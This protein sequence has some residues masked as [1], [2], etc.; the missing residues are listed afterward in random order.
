[1]QDAVAQGQA[2]GM[3]PPGADPTNAI[4]GMLGGLMNGGGGPGGGGGRG[5][6]GGGGGGRG[7]RGGGGGGGGGAFRNFN[8]AQPHGSIFY[9]G[10]NS[11]LNSA[12]WSPNLTPVSKPE[13]YSNNY[14]LTIG[15]S[16]YIPG[17]TK[18][19]TK[20]F[21]FI[22]LTGKKNLTA[23][24]FNGTVPTAL[25]RAGNFLGATTGGSTGSAIT[26][27]DPVT[28]AALLNNNLANASV[29]I[30]QTALNLI[31][32][33]YPLPN[34]AANAQGNNY[35]TI[36][37]A[38]NNSVA[39]NTRYVRT[40]GSSTNT[41]A[42]RFGGGGGGGRRNGNSNAPPSLRQNINLSYNFSHSAA[43]QRQIFLPL[44]GANESDGNA[45]TAGYTIGYGR[46]S[47]NA[48]LG[49]NRLNTQTRNYFTNTANDPTTAL[50]INVPNLT[51]GFANPRFYNGLPSL[52]LGTFTSISNTTPSQ[53][54]NQTISFSDFVA[55]RVKEAQY[56]L[57][58]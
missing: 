41:P 23:D 28:G 1:M 9:Q 31:N 13:S 4:V 25:E 40:L 33:Y 27:Y 14:G 54:I 49:W 37:N 17:L 30:S 36:T 26:L 3:I 2:S 11:A 43:D 22:N 52:S 51:G 35:Q 6:G 53:T 48:S 45:V 32:A 42:G 47:N 46:L 10:S 5:G 55:W 16:P 39:I 57:W 58:V 12:P 24:I 38:G 19:N 21:V 50:G 18:P 44:G 34:I 20:Q 56:A 8:P 29:P 7:G 15:G